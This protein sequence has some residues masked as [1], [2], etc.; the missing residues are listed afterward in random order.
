[1]KEQK[2]WSPIMALIRF[3]FRLFL[4]AMRDFFLSPVSFA[5]VVIDILARNKLKEQSLFY[6]LMMTGR[7]SDKWINLFEQYDEHGNELPEGIVAPDNQIE[8]KTE[9]KATE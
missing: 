1:M 3:Q 7:K 4:D 6:R 9:K 5:C 2:D 8:G